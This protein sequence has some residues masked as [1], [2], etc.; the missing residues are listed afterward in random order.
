MMKKKKSIIKKLRIIMV[1]PL[2]LFLGL[3]I[4]N[5]QNTPKAKGV[6]VKQNDTLST[7]SQSMT[8]RSVSEGGVPP[9]LQSAVKRPAGEGDPIPPPPPQSAKK[10]PVGEGEP[11]PPPPPQ[12][13]EKRPVGEGEPIPPPPQSIEKRPVGEGEPIPP[14]PAPKKQ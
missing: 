5:A 14:P 7:S 10:R 12:S 6:K 9:S 3:V 1:I 4:T 2:Y 11:I 13:A 8:K